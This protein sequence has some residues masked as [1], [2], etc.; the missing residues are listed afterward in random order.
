M[1]KLLSTIIAVSLLSSIAFAQV[2]I[3]LR[4]G[5]N[6]ANQHSSDYSGDI[7]PGFFAG[8]YMTGNLS[9]SIAIQPELYYSVMGSKSGAIKINLGYVSIPLLLRF[10]INESVNIHLGPQFG[11]L[12]SAKDEDSDDVKALYKDLD[13]G[14]VLGVG[15]DLGAF[16]AGVRYYMGFA[17]T[18]EDSGI[19]AVAPK[20]NNTAIQ[21]FVGYRI[22]GGD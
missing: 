18:M 9:E 17:D 7:K 3:G 16:N 4:G 12:A 6:L 20:T 14:G 8:A 2:S 15:I 11:I 5:L 13:V 10:N 1:K 21:L 19:L 22:F